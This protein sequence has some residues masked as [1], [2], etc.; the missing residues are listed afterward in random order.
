MRDEESFKLKKIIKHL[1]SIKG[2]HT[3]LVSVYVPAGGNLQDTVDQVKNEQS[4]A[5][6]IK[7]KAT[8]KNVVDA[9]EKI[10]QHLRT[11]RKT[12]KNGL[13]VFAGNA[14]ETEGR[15]EIKVWS[16]EPP[17]E[18]KQKIYW[19]D[20]V[21]VLEPL[22]EMVREKEVYGLLVMDSKEADIGLL[23]GKRIEPVMHFD[24]AV[25][26]KTTKGGYC[27][28]GDTKIQLGDGIVKNLKDIKRGEHLAALDFD[29]LDGK[30]GKCIGLVERRPSHA[31]KIRT[32]APANDVFATGEHLFF[33]VDGLGFAEKSAD[34][35]KPGDFLLFSKRITVTEAEKN[36]F[37]GDLA[38]IL[39]Y[40]LGDGEADLNRIRLFEKNTRLIKY[41]KNLAGKVFGANTHLRFRKDK[42][43]H[44]L[45]IYGR[46]TLDFVRRNFDVFGNARLR[47][48]PETVQ[49]SNSATVA[50][51]VRGLFDAEGH[52][53]HR[54]LGITMASPSLLKTLQILLL[55]FGIVSSVTERDFTFSRAATLRITDPNSVKTF[56]NLIGFS[57]KEKMGKLKKNLRKVHGEESHIYQAPVDGR[58]VGSLLSS[59]GLRRNL[60]KY[61]MFFS[62]RRSASHDVFRKILL[63][64]RSE[65][66]KERDPERKANLKKAARALGRISDSDLIKV[67]VKSVG[68]VRTREPF[69]D[70]TV[71]PTN[72]FVAG[73]FV[74]HNS[75]MRYQHVRE[76]LLN[77]FMKKIAAAAAKVFLEQQDLKGIIVGGPGPNKDIFMKEEYLQD[78]VRKKVLGVKDVSYTGEYG[79]EELVSRSQ[80]LLKEASLVHER[81]ILEKF[82]REMQKGGNVVYGLEKTSHALGLGAVDT[83]LVSESFEL[84]RAN[85][86]CQSGHET[87]ANLIEFELDK[88]KCDVCGTAMAVSD[89]KEVVEILTEKAIEF[90]SKVEL[91]SAE[92]RE[93][94]QFKELGGIGALLR[95]KV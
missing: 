91:I 75:Q 42:G 48:I 38:Q 73:G 5:S 62:G 41:Y 14:S 83:L 9:L 19:C 81:G 49:R 26:G 10:V 60:R 4:T 31:Y 86:R 88:Q 21:F 95:Y 69:Y 33:V 35:L 40:M 65:V 29:K 93:G 12:P 51:F 43:Y 78:Q 64:L 46:E 25:P 63:Q 72:N 2:R 58:A 50:R 44:E 71:N 22:R 68:K 74:V 79:L 34:S 76:A 55:R 16:V 61:N 28:S 59:L 89:K 53:D 77:D 11:F 47:K 82:F 18:M 45:T 15:P 17:E 87:E 54:M 67:K 57:S 92:T 66:G 94:K 56:A 30:L 24:S 20:Q 39:G 70:I 27:L 90:G 52:V 13:A 80:D 32:C 3:E 7:S 8:R 85:L 37:N 36:K 6:N 84:W 1:D 23:M